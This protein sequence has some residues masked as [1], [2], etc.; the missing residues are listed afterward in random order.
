MS[1][2]V[3]I[4]GFTREKGI[5]AACEA[6][7]T[8]IGL[9]LDRSPRQVDPETAARLLAAV[10]PGVERVAVHRQPTAAQLAAMAS[11]PFDLLQVSAPWR[12]T[13]PSGWGLVRAY[14]DGEDL[15][16]RVRRDWQ[17]GRRDL[18]SMRG[19]FLL[20]GPR[21]GGM[22]IRAQV[23]RARRVAALGACVLAGGLSPDNVADA[24][25]RIRPAGV[26]VSSGVEQDPG[27]KD[28]DRVR[29]FVAAALEAA[30]SHREDR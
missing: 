6:G 14:A 27:R 9:V 3:K 29:D 10:P 25:E 18:R 17:P 30:A 8:A 1:F 2:V 24:V 19:T 4:C 21:G 5:A 13:P 26:D 20:D 22:G 12:G 16:A 7:A 11:L 23:D 28:P 15:L